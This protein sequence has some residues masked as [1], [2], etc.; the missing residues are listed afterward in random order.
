M[1][2]C[3]L[4]LIL[5]LAAVPYSGAANVT[6]VRTTPVPTTEG[7]CWSCAF[8]FGVSVGALNN[9]NTGLLMVFG[10]M[11]FCCAVV[12]GVTCLSCYCMFRQKQ[13]VKDT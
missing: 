10:T 7:F 5:A 8:D 6:N 3:L 11:L 4:G 1:S 12:G 9:Y 13:Q 2:T